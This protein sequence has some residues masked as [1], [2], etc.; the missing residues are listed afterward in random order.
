MLVPAK[1][2]LAVH[3]GG[4]RVESIIELVLREHLERR[5]VSDHDRVAFAACQVGTPTRAHGRGEDVRLAVAASQ[6]LM[7]LAGRGV[8]PGESREGG[9][10]ETGWCVGE[11]RG[12]K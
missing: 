1:Q 11:A 2:N 4:G 12:G 8:G 7:G 3:H 5:A 6:L 10:R 9:Y